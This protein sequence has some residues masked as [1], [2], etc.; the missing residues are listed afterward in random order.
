MTGNA[1]IVVGYDG[2]E[3]ARSA[4]FWAAREALRR[5]AALRVVQ[6]YQWPGPQA[7]RDLGRYEAL[8]ADQARSQVRTLVGDLAAAHPALD[9]TGSAV[10]GDA[11]S[12]LIVA[13]RGV[14]LVVVGSRGLGGFAGLLIGSVSMHVAGH[15]HSS[16]AV[17]RGQP[18][19][20]GRVVVA[21][22][23]NVPSE[24]VAEQAFELA[25]GT[26]AELVAVRGW[27]APVVPW[28]NG[29][30]AG[31]T[32]HAEAREA[33][34]QVVLD[35]LA[36]WR[37][38]F[39]DVPVRIV[40]APGDTGAAVVEETLC[41]G[42]VV[43]DGRPGPLGVPLSRVTRRVLHHARCPVLVARHHHD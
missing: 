5:H 1:E 21:V 29:T 15:A 14:D 36:L 16:V 26:G 20:R 35:A 32:N 22:N 27:R 3:H 6:V 41:A 39:P 23:G 19:P 7:P 25:A 2:S 31:P 28:H 43:V 40:L 38:K 24:V 4:A 12:A 37:E 8:L 9:V 42:A 34:R 11:G 18:I 10:R 33:E 13:S 30:S 17:V